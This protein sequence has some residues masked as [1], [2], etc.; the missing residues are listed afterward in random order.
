MQQTAWWYLL[1]NE[2]KRIDKILHVHILENMENCHKVD[3][4][5][6]YLK[7]EEN[8]EIRIRKRG[9][10]D[11][12]TYS[13]HAKTM[14]QNGELVET[15]SQLTEDEYEV[16]LKQADPHM[17]EIRKTRYCFTYNELY[18]ELDLYSLWRHQAIVEVETNSGTGCIQFPDFVKVQQELTGLAEYKNASLAKK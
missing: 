4:V 15:E 14:A 16:L 1:S 5:R 17:R 10:G 3:V 8:E 9:I 12:Y 7:S 6:T 18:F 13:L 2:I 11:Y